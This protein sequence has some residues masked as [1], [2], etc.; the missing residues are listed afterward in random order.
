MIA[1]G[2]CAAGLFTN[3]DGLRDQLLK[4]SESTTV[5]TLW[6]LPILDAHK[7]EI[8]GAEADLNNMGKGRYGGAST[9]AAFLQVRPFAL[10]R[11]R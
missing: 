2:D 11:N 3:D 5:E 1:L 9:A 4:A 8:K 7:E 6:P 10:F